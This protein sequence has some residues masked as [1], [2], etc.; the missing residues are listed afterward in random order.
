MSIR[1]VSLVE[2]ADRTCL[3]LEGGSRRGTALIG[4]PR[5]AVRAR[6]TDPLLF[7]H[8]LF[9]ETRE[10]VHTYL[11]LGF[12]VDVIDFGAPLPAGGG[13]YQTSLTF[14]HQLHMIESALVPGAIKVNWLTA[15]NPIVRNA[16][17]TVRAKEI[18]RAHV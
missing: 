14:H 16:R 18:G 6:D 15:S 10:L 3:R 1:A 8:S 7:N 13:P 4:I 17:E 5:D 9:W 2:H 12:D 11:R